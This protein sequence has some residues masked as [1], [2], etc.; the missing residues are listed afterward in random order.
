MLEI[1]NGGMTDDEYKT[2]MSLWAILAAPLLAGNDLRS[3]TPAVQEILTN[4][5]VIAVN[6]DPD[7]KQGRRI[8]TSGAAE[9]AQ[10]AQEVWTRPL[11]GG[12]LAVGLFNRAAQPATM[13]VK[14]S[15]L[16]MTSAPAHVRDLWAHRDLSLKGGDYSVEVPAHGVVMLRVAH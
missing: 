1:G 9:G 11:S 6:Q 15:D 7:G 14:W 8:A 16:G 10:P 12:A 13:T 3:M 5:D 4:R 2:H